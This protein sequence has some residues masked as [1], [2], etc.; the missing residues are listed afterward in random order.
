MIRSAKADPSIGL[1][2]RRVQIVMAYTVACIGVLLGL[3]MVPAG[4]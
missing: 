1:V 2:G 4:E 3:S